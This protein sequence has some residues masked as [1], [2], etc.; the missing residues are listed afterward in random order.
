MTT[1]DHSVDRMP[2]ERNE[3]VKK[4]T[5]FAVAALIVLSIVSMF[6]NITKTPVDSSYSV[7]IVQE[8]AIPVRDNRADRFT[9]ELTSAVNQNNRAQ[10]APSSNLPDLTAI[11]ERI[12][13][14]RNERQSIPAA[15]TASKPKE[16]PSYSSKH[17]RADEKAPMVQS[18]SVPA[19]AT[20]GQDR[21]LLNQLLGHSVNQISQPALA[22]APVE[23]PQPT[24]PFIA[25]GSVIPVR[26]DT[27]MNSD[28]SQPVV[29]GVVTHNV[30]DFFNR[31]LL[32]PAGSRVIGNT[33]VLAVN[34][35][36]INQRSGLALTRII[37]PDG[38]VIDLED[39]GVDQFGEAGLTGD[40]D[41][42]T[43]ARLGG[44][45]AYAFIGLG[46]AL[47]IENGEAQSSRDDATRAV[48]ERL[49]QNGAAFAN[50]YLA[51]V[52]TIRIPA[53]TR[54]NILTAKR[55]HIRL[56]NKGAK[57]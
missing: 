5:L 34:N 47:T 9:D 25:A 12:V 48:T 27:P 30:Y 55:L 52:P 10:A 14:E 15:I 42:H 2:T 46:P 36:A 26:I 43:L 32:I 39:I 54:V 19:M 56:L 38:S 18:A 51:L 53:G 50:R 49:V 21:A 16:A 29:R 24:G 35:L 57:T 44:M 1:S 23:Q 13:A 20:P 41:K 40:V 6:Y 3:G 45:T 8:T 7:P 28:L 11:T 17:A 37:R 22:P 33:F 31:E 4:K